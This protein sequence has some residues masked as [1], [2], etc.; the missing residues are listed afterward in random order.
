[1]VVAAVAASALTG[2]TRAAR[3][4]AGTKPSMDGVPL[5]GRGTD[6]EGAAEQKKGAP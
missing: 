4:L 2:Y 5:P 1:M 3:A 6:E